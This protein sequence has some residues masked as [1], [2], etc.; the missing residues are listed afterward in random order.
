MTDAELDAFARRQA[1]DVTIAMQLTLL[2][3]LFLI[4]WSLL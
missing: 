4:L 3:C 1:D 2:V